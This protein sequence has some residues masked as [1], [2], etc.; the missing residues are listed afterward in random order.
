MCCIESSRIARLSTYVVVV[1]LELDVVNSY[2]MLSLA[3]HLRSGYRKTR[4]KYM[5]SVSP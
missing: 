3:N 2:P 1:I 4:K 5:L